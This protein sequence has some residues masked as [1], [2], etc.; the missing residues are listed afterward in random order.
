MDEVEYEPTNDWWTWLAES[1]SHVLDKLE[2]IA[3]A[4]EQIADHYDKVEGF[5]DRMLS[6][7]TSFGTQWVVLG[8]EPNGD[9][10]A[11]LV[12]DPRV[13][14]P[15]SVEMEVHG[16]GRVELSMLLGLL[17]HKWLDHLSKKYPEPF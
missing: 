4:Q 6:S 9:Y 14:E 13:G 12:L 16:A 17:Y 15:L 2:R 1:R 3:T 10:F 8:R 7:L 5:S 11:G